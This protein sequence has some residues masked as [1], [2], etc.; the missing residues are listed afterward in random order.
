VLRDLTWAQTTIAQARTKEMA[1]LEKLLEDAG[2]KL[3][4]VACEIVGVSGRAMLEA[5]IDGQRNPAA[6]ADLAKRQLR[7]K[8]P[9]LNEA[10]RGRFNDHHASPFGP[11]ANCV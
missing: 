3:S 4:S 1:R 5:L 9:A 8:I 6:L 11:P 10:L 2:I 7:K